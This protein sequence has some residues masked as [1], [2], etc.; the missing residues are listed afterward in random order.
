ML[1]YRDI[2]LLMNR[3]TFIRVLR[4]LADLLEQIRPDTQA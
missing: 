3:T 4:T 1:T 2:A